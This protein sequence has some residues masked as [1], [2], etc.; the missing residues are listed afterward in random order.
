VL[1]IEFFP[2]PIE[3]FLSVNDE[4]EDESRHNKRKKDCKGFRSLKT[5]IIQDDSSSLPSIVEKF[6]CRPANEIFIEVS[7]DLCAPIITKIDLPQSK[8]GP[9]TI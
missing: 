4:H 6:C 8:S 1:F 7:R 9:A 2:F 3:G 5:A